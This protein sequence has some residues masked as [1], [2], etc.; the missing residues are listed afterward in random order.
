LTC[1]FAGVFEGD[2]EKFFYR[3]WSMGVENRISPLRAV[4]KKSRT[5]SVEMTVL[6]G[7][8]GSKATADSSAALRN[9][10][11]GDGKGNSLL[12]LR[13]DIPA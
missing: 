13:I 3:G 6:G 4:R 7:M 5:A 9:D 10:K 2:F 11:K 8:G 1:E 12:R